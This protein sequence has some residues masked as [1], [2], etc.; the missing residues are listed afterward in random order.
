MI[1]D[2]WL[3][4]KGKRFEG[5]VVKVRSGLE[6]MQRMHKAVGGLIRA[7][8]AI[9]DGKYKDVSISGDFFCFPRNCVDRLA[10][11]LEDCYVGNVSSVITDF[12]QTEGLEIPGVTTEDWK[13][14]FRI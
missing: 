5:R 4:Q 1:N 6:V 7:E 3:Y 11:K 12:Y 10:L 9:E 13:H 2:A 8:F 14:I